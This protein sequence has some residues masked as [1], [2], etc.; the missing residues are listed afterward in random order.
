[1]VSDNIKAA[2]LTIGTIVGGFLLMIAALALFAGGCYLII[3]GLYIVTFFVC[4]TLLG[5]SAEVA[6]VTTLVMLLVI[7]LTTVMW[8]EVVIMY[9]RHQSDLMRKKLYNDRNN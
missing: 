7:L 2:L 8:D 4:V 5:L 6:V 9:R 3:N 1:M